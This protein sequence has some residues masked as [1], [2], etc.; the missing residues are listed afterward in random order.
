[1]GKFRSQFPS[2]HAGRG[3]GILRQFFFTLNNFFRVQLC[4]GFG[5][6]QGQG[7]RL[8]LGRSLE[9]SDCVSCSARLVF[10]LHPIFLK[11]EAEQASLPWLRIGRKL[12][13]A[14]AYA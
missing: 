4:L 9:E 3:A 11:E 13:Q 6:Q 10:L 8:R 12:V 14:S 1:M 5:V 2:L 7:L